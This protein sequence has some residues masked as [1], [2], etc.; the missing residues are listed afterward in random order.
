MFAGIVFCGVDPAL[1]TFCC[2]M[3]PE[4]EPGGVYAASRNGLK[5]T[6]MVGSLWLAI[7]KGAGVPKDV[8]VPH[9]GQLLIPGWSAVPHD[10]HCMA[11]TSSRV[12]APRYFA[13]AR[14]F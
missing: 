9:R 3:P 11:V 10:T 8:G 13:D 4:G 5:S 1:Y 14:S 7:D 12:R 2:G 6:G